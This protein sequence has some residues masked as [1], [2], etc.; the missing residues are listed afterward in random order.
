MAR[1][2]NITPDANQFLCQERDQQFPIKPSSGT[3]VVMLGHVAQLGEA[4]QSL[5]HQLNLPRCAVRSQ[6]VR[7]RTGGAGRKHDGRRCWSRV[8]CAPGRRVGRRAVSRRRRR[9]LGPPMGCQECSTRRDGGPNFG[10]QLVH[11]NLQMRSFYAT[12]STLNHSKQMKHG[13]Y[14]QGRKS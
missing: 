3:P 5:K 7:R 1:G 9:Y 2:G 8:V 10:A 11:N 6:N 12:E 14:E 13:E 4:L